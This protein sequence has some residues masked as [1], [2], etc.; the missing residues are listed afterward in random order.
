MAHSYSISCYFI[1]WNWGLLKIRD[2]GSPICRPSLAC[3]LFSYDTRAKVVYYILKY[4]ILNIKIRLIFHG[5]WKYYEIQISLS[6]IKCY[7]N[8][9]MLIHLHIICSCF[10]A[11]MTK[12]NSCNRDHM[13]CKSENNYYLALYTKGC[14]LLHKTALNFL[15]LKPFPSITISASHHF[16]EEKEELTIA[17]FL[18]Y[19]RRYVSTPLASLSSSPLNEASNATVKCEMWCSA[20]ITCQAYCLMLARICGAGF[21]SWLQG[22]NK[23][24]PHPSFLPTQLWLRTAHCI[25][26]LTLLPIHFSS[27]P[28]PLPSLVQKRTTTLLN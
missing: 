15:F 25:P 6:I 16:Y 20:S 3:W 1:P 14:W 23:C 4:F 24:V 10:H 22:V 12:L 19:V 27:F 13:T 21:L 11:T 26:A 5:I 28:F 9:A 7:W 2:H 17:E 18:L 8:T